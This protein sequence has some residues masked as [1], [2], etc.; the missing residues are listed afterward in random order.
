MIDSYFLSKE[1]N[2]LNPIIKALEREIKEILFYV[3]EHGMNFYINDWKLRV[4]KI[5][6]LTMKLEDKEQL[7]KILIVNS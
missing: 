5:L 7:K 3:I 6:I 4:I 1:Q 2:T